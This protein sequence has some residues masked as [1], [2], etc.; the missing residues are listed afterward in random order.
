VRSEEEIDNRKTCFNASVF[1]GCM[2]SD[3]LGRT[4]AKGGLHKPECFR[5]SWLQ[6]RNKVSRLF[7]MQGYAYLD[8]LLADLIV[9]LDYHVQHP[10]PLLSKV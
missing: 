9:R 1:V 6:K 2:P 3:G 7:A 8:L 5:W 4:N 10:G